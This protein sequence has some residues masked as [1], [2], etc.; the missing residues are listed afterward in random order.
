M[1]RLRINITAALASDEAFIYLGAAAT[2]A[3]AHAR[4]LVHVLLPV[5]LPI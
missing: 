3:Y 4:A 5:L 2:Y 1:R